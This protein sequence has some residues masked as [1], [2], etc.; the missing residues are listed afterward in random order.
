MGKFLSVVTLLV[1]CG[2]DDP[3]PSCQQAM[4]HYYDAGCLFYDLQTGQPIPV[5]E[6]ISFCHQV[7][8]AAPMSCEDD[9]ADWLFCL[10][11]VPSPASSNADCDCT[12]EQDALLTCE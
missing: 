1:A 11:G 12:Q 2:G 7:K 6:R 9:V 3:P 8:A 5:N 4:T 10:E